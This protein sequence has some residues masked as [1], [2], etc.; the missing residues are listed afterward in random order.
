MNSV[1]T[2]RLVAAHQQCARKAF[3]L[4]RDAPTPQPHE[5]EIAIHE[6]AAQRRVA[7]M[8]EENNG[9]KKTPV[10]VPVGDLQATCEA[11]THGRKHGER[12]PHLVIGTRTPSSSDKA[13]LAFA[14]FT[15]GEKNRRRPSFGVIVP[16]AGDPKRMKLGPLYSGISRSVEGLRQWARQ[17]PPDPPALVMGKQCQT[18]EFR[19]H[20]RADA[21]KSDSL[22]LLERMTPKIAAKYQKKGIFTLTQLSY[23]YRPRRRPKKSL[24]KAP[25]PF[26]VELQ[27]LAIRTKKIYLHE[28]PSLSPQPVELFLDIEGI[29]D[30]DFNYLIGVTVK[31]GERIK[32]Y[33]FWADDIDDEASI[34]K[35]FFALADKYP[36]APIY[37]YGS[38]ERRAMERGAE[39]HRLNCKDVL[40]KLVN[41]NSLVY[42]KVYFPTRSNRLKDLGVAV[43]ASWTTPNPSGAQSV[44]WRYRWE[45][46]GGRKF[47]AKLLA[48]NQADCNA[49]RLLTTE[50]QSL[51]TGADK[52]V[53]VDFT[54]KPKQ[55]ATPTGE[56]IHRA[57][58]GIINSAHLEYQQK[59]IRLRGDA[60]EAGSCDA[61]PTP[62]ARLH[63]PSKRQAATTAAKVIRVQTKRTCPQ[64]P[65]ASL[66]PLYVASQHVQTDLVFSR[67]GARKR[68]VKYVGQ[69]A[70][71]PICGY[72]YL[73]PVISRLKRRMFGHSFL[74]WVAYQR[75]VLMLPFG[76]IKQTLAVLFSE[77]VG[78]STICKFMHQMASDYSHTATLLS[79]HIL[80]SP[81]VHVDETKI[82]IQGRNWYVWVLTD[83]KHVVF[84][85]TDSREA[86]VIQKVLDGYQGVLVSD[87]YGGY[88]SMPCRQQKCLV[89]L[90]RDLNDDLW[91]H[92][93]L[94]EYE[95]FV[96]RVRD[97][98]VPMFADVERF[99][100]KKRY[101]HKHMKFVDR[102]YRQSIEGVTWVSDII[103]TYQKRFLRYRE[104]L[105]LFL[106]ENGIPW[107]NN[108]AERAIRQL[109]VQ[110]K[111]SGSFFVKGATDYLTMLGIAQSCRF[112]DKSFLRFLLSE[113][114]DVDAFTD[115]KRRRR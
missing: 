90:I 65:H 109:A 18:C 54:N 17:L 32:H 66:Q 20:C 15:L 108:M 51:S 43:G 73:P 92:P 27:A 75:V 29:P 13:H 106:S 80:K 93:F 55:L 4:L 102:F 110:R 57:F 74:S 12:E 100:L 79:R 22:Y 104:S 88:D 107:N 48:Y 33:S 85:L 70:S 26:N 21:E 50:L 25:T 68:L 23:V 113:K 36:N 81:F 63:L 114:K 112:Q 101:L 103:Q 41:V 78:K 42:G 62:P 72:S 105:F 82:S 34:L 46:S 69:K 98:L 9:P 47:K 56:V 16:F 61:L 76:P 94:T 38:Y 30:Q 83:G 71:C 6:R 95:M 99:G 86:N 77:S 115:R 58:D 19:E 11:V 24:G 45:D 87:F 3:F 60:E 96:S 53:D 64:H 111:I 59:R 40:A 1:I 44:A 28:R 89:H 8:A 91:K 52:R 7:Y 39:Q 84:H 10:V 14:G 31:R 2:S 5:Y 67:N 97:L 35:E 49:L 37:H